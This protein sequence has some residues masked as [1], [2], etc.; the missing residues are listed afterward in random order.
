M[1]SVANKIIYIYI[2]G[3]SAQQ[4]IPSSHP[5]DN[6]VKFITYESLSAWLCLILVYWK[7]TRRRRHCTILLECNIY[8]NY[9]RYAKYILQC[10]SNQ[11]NTLQCNWITIQLWITITMNYMYTMTK[12]TITSMTM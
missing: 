9:V 10:R 8:Y 7:K 11:T 6:N 1:Y 5:I 12:Q 4:G 3:G 2:R